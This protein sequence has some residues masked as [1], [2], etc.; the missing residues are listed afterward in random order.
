MDETTKPGGNTGPLTVDEAVDRLMAEAP[1]DEDKPEPEGDDTPDEADAEDDATEDED[2]PDED[3]A[4]SEDDD[5]AEDDADDETDQAGEQSKYVDDAAK[6][7]LDGEEVSIADLKAGAMRHADYTRKTQE[8][9]ERG[10]RYEEDLSKLGEYSGQIV[11]TLTLANELVKFAEPQPPSHDLKD[12]DPVAWGNAMHDYRMAKEQYDAVV[13]RV[14]QGLSQTKEVTDANANVADAKTW[15]AARKKLREAVPDLNDPKKAPAVQQAVWEIAQ[16]VGFDAD[17]VKGW[18]DPRIAHL[19][20]LASQALKLEQ[21]K[22]KAS[23]KI[24]GK[25]PVQKPGKRVSSKEGRRRNFDATMKRL[26]STGSENDA[27]EAL[28]AA[29]GID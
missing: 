7:L 24:E 5:D 13:Q 27:I 10:K 29:R 1:Q 18:K 23:K 20:V 6:V 3:Q 28:M 8:I 4:D 19:A 9:A 11:Q 26:A 16:K 17:E 22:P 15:E 2:S 21:A 14:R 12:M 25:P